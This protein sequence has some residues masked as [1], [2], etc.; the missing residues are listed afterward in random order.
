MITFGEK[1]KIVNISEWIIIQNKAEEKRITWMYLCV[2][3][4]SV[5]S[6]LKED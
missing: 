2:E 5:L 6:R 4:N 1:Q 3:R